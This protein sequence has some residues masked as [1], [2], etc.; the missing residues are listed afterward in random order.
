MANTTSIAAS[1]MQS[2]QV[3]L[4]TAAHNL[5][6][7]NTPEFRRQQAVHTAQTGGGVSTTLRR[8]A[9]P[10]ADAQADVVDLLR[11]R[12]AFVANL[13]VFKSHDSMA[14]KLLDVRV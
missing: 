6:N 12:H 1:G 4:G 5:A 9:A 8:A 13:K 2:A 7:V 14:G 11:A 10:G 3:R